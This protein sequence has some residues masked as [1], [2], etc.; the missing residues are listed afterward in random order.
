MTS[1][2]V[3]VLALIFGAWENAGRAGFMATLPLSVRDVSI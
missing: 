3:I 2:Y 1:Y